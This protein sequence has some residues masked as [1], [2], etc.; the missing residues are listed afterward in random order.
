[1]TALVLGFLV[2]EKSWVQN[3]NRWILDMPH[4]VHLF[5]EATRHGLLT[6]GRR[7]MW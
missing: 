5:W 7:V 6:L 4:A 2:L 1:M 3:F